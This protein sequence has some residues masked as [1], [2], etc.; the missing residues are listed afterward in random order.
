MKAGAYNMG[1]PLLMKNENGG[2]V[3]VCYIACYGSAP[4][5]SAFG[6]WLFHALFSPLRWRQPD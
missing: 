3:I 6:F 4:G 1:M 5:A 2:G